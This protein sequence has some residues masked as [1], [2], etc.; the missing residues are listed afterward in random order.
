[1]TSYAIKIITFQPHEIDKTRETLE[2]WGLKGWSVK[3]AWS[4]GQWVRIIIQKPLEPVGPEIVGQKQKQRQ[5][6]SFG[7]VAQDEEDQRGD[8]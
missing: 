1:M 4:E 5:L 2:H 8:E 7:A 3:A 6:P